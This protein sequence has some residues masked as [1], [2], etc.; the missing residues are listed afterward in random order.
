[1]SEQAG[2]VRELVASLGS[3]ERW[4]AVA[5]AMVGLIVWT[6][7]KEPFA[8]WPPPLWYVVWSWAIWTLVLPVAVVGFQVWA[9]EWAQR[10]RGVTIVPSSATP[11]TDDLLAKNRALL[12]EV[13]ALKAQLATKP[14]GSTP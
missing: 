10:V 9:T 12:D 6:W 13:A 2:D 7:A 14:A 8:D 11:K 4:Y 3:L 1:M 5:S